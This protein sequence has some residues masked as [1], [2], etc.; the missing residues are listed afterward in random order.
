MV[1]NGID[2]PEVWK[3][4]LRGKRVGLVTAASGYDATLRRSVDC[5]LAEGVRI[6][7]LFA[8]EHGLRGAAAA[9]EDVA[10][11]SDPR[12][13]LPV[14][15][16]YRKESRRFS[17][18]MF[19]D[20]DV[21]VYDIGDVGARFFTYLSTLLNTVEDCARFHTPLVVLDRINPLGGCVAEGASL[22][23][24]C[25]S[26]V[27]AYP[28]PIR[29]A[30]TPG[31]FALMANVQERFGCE[32]TVV[33]AVGWRRGWLH[34]QTGLP[35][36]PPS[37]ALQHFEN[38]LLYPGT[39]LA[40]GTNLSEGRG[41]A[42]P[43]LL[44]GAPYADADTLAHRLTSL[45]LPG[46]GFLPAA[47]TPSAGKHAGVA[48]EGVRIILTDA[49]VCRPV[50]VG[51]ALLDAVRELWPGAFAFLPPGGESNLPMIDLLS[52]NHR[53]REGQTGAGYLA[54]AATDCEAFLARSKPYRLY[55][56][57]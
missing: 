27:G 36:V 16:L 33:E 54:G 18:N 14:Y 2:R 21:M 6:T 35:W 39:C 12:T 29:Y 48:C 51:L 24:D 23:L 43:F 22:R 56:G 25:R 15:S 34:P 5:M 31:E 11:A 17:E 32:L 40:E 41:T 46:V 49:H 26:F 1:Q 19:H 45:A 53:L 13:G 3:K 30:L 28:L 44:L 8:P 37:P 10:A 38:A 4:L 47:F 52:G 42:A 9:G 20:V 57:D 55:E 50:T 7:A